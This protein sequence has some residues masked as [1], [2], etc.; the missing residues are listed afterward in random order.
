MMKIKE[1]KFKTK[2][3]QANQPK[4]ELSRY[5]KACSKFKQTQKIKSIELDDKLEAKLLTSNLFYV[6]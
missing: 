1:F 5:Q 6:L 3:D 4:F 2:N